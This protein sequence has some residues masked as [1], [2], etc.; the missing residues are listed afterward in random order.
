MCAR[1]SVPGRFC[2]LGRVLCARF[3]LL[4]L[5]ASL[6]PPSFFAQLS[7]T[8]HLAEPGFWPT[9]SAASRNEYAGTA[10]C[11]SCHAQ[12]VASQ[13]LTAMAQTTSHIS[14]STILRSH[15]DLNFTIG[16]YRYEIKT[17]AHQSLYSVTDGKRTITAPL[18]WAFG[19]GHVG[20]SY[21]FK[22]SDGKLYEARVTYF[23]TIDRLHFTPARALETPKDLEEE[24]YRP[25]ES[26]EV[27]RCF[28]CHNTAASPGD[29]FDETNLI[30]GVSCEACH[31][32]G[33]QH[34]AAEQ[35][36]LA[37]TGPVGGEFIFNPARLIPAD[38]VDFCGSCHGTFWDVKLSNAKGVDT[39]K[40]QPYRLES[41]KCWRKG[42]ARLTCVACHNPH[43][44]LQTESSAY[45][46]ACLSCHLTAGEKKTAE[47]TAA[48]CPVG[49]KECVSCHMPRVDVPDMHYQFTDHRIRIL[50][51]GDGYPE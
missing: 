32:P 22:K 51:P 39:A 19:N 50:H 43:E 28:A 16:R 47:R 41:S 7:T 35:A 34:V 36:A 40:S 3:L 15:P 33:A 48:F 12:L 1:D 11:A 13:K 24:M 9:R 26:P 37:T 18:L 4:A 5:A 31:G 29:Q 8:D 10:Q 46:K 27:A 14:D 20:Q 42:D 25:L 49:I 6:Q 2:P 30:L 45:D 21:L 23:G 38:S 44:P 17:D